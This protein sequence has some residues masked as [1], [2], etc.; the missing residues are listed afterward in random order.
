MTD[1][2]DLENTAA[3]NNSASLGFQEGQT[4]SSVNNSARELQALLRRDW[5]GTATGG[6]EWRNPVKGMTITRISSTQIRVVGNDA[7]AFFKVGQ[8]IKVTHAT[9]NP[10]YAFITAS[11]FG[12]DTNITCDDFDDVAPDHEFRA[13]ANGIFFHCA[14][15]S[16][17][18]HGIG[19]GAFEGS[20][21][22][23]FEVPPSADAAGI[24]TA[25]TNAI[26][27]GKIVLLNSGTYSITTPIS[28]TGKVQVWGRGT[29]RTILQAANNLNQNVINITGSGTSDVVLRD[30]TIDGNENNQVAG[31]GIALTADAAERIRFEN[32]WVAN[33]YQSAIRVAPVTTPPLDM[34][35]LGCKISETGDH[36]I[37]LVAPTNFLDRVYI[38]GCTIEN[39]GNQGALVATASGIWAKGQIHVRGCTINMNQSSGTHTGA[40]VHLVQPDAAATPT[41][42][43]YNS[44]V[45][46][47]RIRGS[48][49]TARGILI[50]GPR[51]L[52]ANCII[53]FVATAMPLLLDGRGAGVEA[54][55]SN[56][57]TGCTFI[58]GL[59]SMIESDAIDNTL[60][61]C[62]FNRNSVAGTCL[63]VRGDNTTIS[64]CI[65]RDSGT[66]A[67]DI[68]AGADATAVMGCLFDSVG[69]AVVDAGTNTVVRDSQPDTSF[70]Y[71]EKTDG[72]VATSGVTTDVTG[73]TAITLPGLGGN[74]TRQFYIS[75]SA[76][77]EINTGSA[78][79]YLYG[80]A[81]GNATDTLLH[82]VTLHHATAPDTNRHNASF[83]PI[84]WTPAAGNK[85]GI[86]LSDA[87]TSASL[88]AGATTRATLLIECDEA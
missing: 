83:G 78:T 80:G 12:T 35:I 17:S 31:R 26:A 10:V 45:S 49:A 66:N 16:T 59:E 24:N 75:F 69:T 53:E 84:R 42:G 2:E 29:Q 71:V 62:S 6:G 85:L 39:P 79:V 20:G 72:D 52:V 77:M 13:D 44:I 68:A 5:E 82:S 23:Y 22:P 11:V 19:K 48:S 28:I 7:T 14:F 34:H 74:G 60:S 32:L 67:I 76:V 63:D 8:K 70:K 36:G 57:I 27:N 1:F 30:F 25:I 15:G 41:A 87:A 50:G 37:E 43:S 86:A 54:C 46:D 33:T 9:G 61:G 18:G 47:C 56:L 4:R 65:F 55:S 3:G 64:S 40:G 21:G 88:I 58:G 38:E 81:N 51:N 73:L